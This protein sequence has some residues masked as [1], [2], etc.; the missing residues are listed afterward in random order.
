MNGPLKIQLAIQGGGA[1]ICALIAAAEALQDL[2]EAGKIE[3]TRLAGT[4][5]GAIVACFLA[6]RDPPIRVIRQRLSDLGESELRKTFPHRTRTGMMGRILFGNPVYDAKKL[7]GFLE[8]FFG[9]KKIG[10]LKRPVFIKAADLLRGKGKSFT[11]KDD[12]FVIDRLVDSCALPFVLRAWRNIG[13]YPLVDGGICENLPSD[14]L[15]D[16]SDEHGEVVAISFR[17]RGVPKA[18]EGLWEFSMALIETAINN[19]MERAK[20]SLRSGSIINLE[21]HMSTFDF[22]DKLTAALDENS[23]HYKLIKLEVEKWFDKTF[24]VQQDP[25]KQTLIVGDPWKAGESTPEGMGTMADL[26]EVYL[27]QHH[28]ARFEISRSAMVITAN[29]LLG[30]D[31][32]R[33]DTPDIVRQV[34]DLKPVD[35]PIY[36]YRL[37]LGAHPNAVFEDRASWTVRDANGEPVET[38]AFPIA[39]PQAPEEDGSESNGPKPDYA[40]DVL[41]FFLPPLAVDDESRKP[42][43]VSQQTLVTGAMAPLRVKGRDGLANTNTRPSGDVGRT[44]IVLFVPTSFPKIRWM[45]LDE[46]GA[47]VLAPVEMSQG[48]IQAYGEPPP[49]FLALGWTGENLPPKGRFGVFLEVPAILGRKTAEPAP[50]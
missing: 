33:A 27:R 3:I 22:G 35:L 12:E 29:S 20:R 39:D 43:R 17:N 9:D 49:G 5:A 16:E 11:A 41:L 31:D 40:R 38:C 2:E 44:D 45:P 21:T 28:D 37:R 13:T 30:K 26:R 46:P 25:A 14:D 23:D 34:V 7:R 36:C 50:G 24:L 47:E 15:I 32:P 4:S 10:E 18:P 8:K 1:K 48:Q 42:Y 19:S 6:P